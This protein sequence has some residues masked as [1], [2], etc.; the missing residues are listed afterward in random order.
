MA[1]RRI[2]I[3]GNSHTAMV[4]RAIR[5][6][7]GLVP[8]GV[9]LEICWLMAGGAGG[10][11]DTTPEAAEAKI[12]ALGRGDLL[13]T[14]FLGTLHNIYGLIENDLPFSVMNGTA[15][16]VLG[17][18][19]IIPA[20]V[21]GSLVDGHLQRDTTMKRYLEI[22]ACR[23]VHF[24]APPP[25]EDPGPPPQQRKDGTPLPN[26]RWAEAQSR[27]AFWTIEAGKVSEYLERIGASPYLTPGGTRD[28]KGFLADAY[29]ASDA[30]HANASY[31]ALLVR[32]FVKMLADDAPSRPT[33][34]PARKQKMWVIG[35]SHGGALDLALKQG[36]FTSEQF[37]IE[38]LRVEKTKHGNTVGDITFPDVLGLVRK[39]GRGNVVVSVIGGNHH[40]T[41]AL[42]QHPQAFQVFSA[43]GSSHPR[44]SKAQVVPRQAIRDALEDLMNRNEL[45]RLER[46]ANNCTVPL[47]H[48]FSPPPRENE[49]DILRTKTTGPL[50]QS[51]RDNGVSPAPLRMACWNAYCEAVR[52]RLKDTGVLFVDPPAEARNERGFILRDYQASDATHAN[53]RYGALALARLCG[54]AA[55]QTRNDS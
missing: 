26:A 9:E 55:M 23:V 40:Q 34:V 15:G 38:I 37:D 17:R 3:V 18:T 14:S 10:H 44:E 25:K 2:L 49:E 16:S 1:R 32:D 8:A 30:T 50:I 36:L 19:Q 45:R 21:I 29:Q 47:F 5:Q 33:P 43:S 24:M 42:A 52:Q 7:P 48:L 31:G 12:R 6:E 51:M 46:L 35:D 22:A 41:L 39:L 53:A 11:G 13:V 54:L 27:L 4:K 28:S 20:S